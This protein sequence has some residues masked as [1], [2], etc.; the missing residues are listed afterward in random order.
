MKAILGI[1]VLCLALGACAEGRQRSTET[2]S[3]DSGVI[4]SS[5]G[6]STLHAVPNVGVNTNNG[7]TVGGVRGRL[8]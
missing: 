1:A 2:R 7:T 3:L 8:Q 5:G 6:E 4:D